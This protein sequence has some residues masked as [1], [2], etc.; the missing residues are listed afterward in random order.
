MAGAVETGLRRDLEKA[1]T[2]LRFVTPVF[3]YLLDH[4]DR[5][6]LNDEVIAR[7]RGI[8]G[9]LA[10]QLYEELAIAAAEDASVDCGKPPFPATVHA[11]AELAEALADVPGMLEHLH[12]IVLEWQVTQRLH[13]GLGV[14]PLISPLL[15]TL[16]G[17]PRAG[18]A[19]V[20]TELLAAQG[21]FA[22]QQQQMQ[23]PLSELPAALLHD[24]L[25]V[26]RHRENHPAAFV[27]AEAAVRSRY[28]EGATRLGLIAC[29]VAEMGDKPIAALAIEHAGLAIFSTALAL[30]SGED[31][32]KCMFAVA[33]GHGTRLALMLRASGMRLAAVQ[34][35][36]LALHPSQGL[37]AKVARIAPERAAALLAG[38]R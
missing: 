31:R 9:D 1:G 29:L 11:I 19:A 21:R 16:I 22:R 10:L 20:A 8:L 25:L 6:L 13:R 15:Q 30:I 4:G 27:A 24:V 14:D 33:G 26:L 2:A 32:Q 12:G 34:T 28:N 23:M 3:R 7:T 37:A 36:L 17:S 18:T 38:S 35:T 5:A